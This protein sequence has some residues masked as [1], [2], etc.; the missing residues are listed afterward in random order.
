MLALGLSGCAAGN[1]EACKVTIN[2]PALDLSD[3]TVLKT[4]PSGHVS[5]YGMAETVVPRVPGMEGGDHGDEVDV[6]F[7][8][9]ARRAAVVSPNS[10]YQVDAETSRGF[11]IMHMAGGKVICRTVD[12]PSDA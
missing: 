1:T 6:D 2:P 5:I 3:L 10:I 11:N 8:A 4:S 12:M 7:N 9:N